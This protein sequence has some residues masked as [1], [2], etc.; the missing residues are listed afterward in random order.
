MIHPLETY[1]RDLRDIRATGAAVPETSFYAPLA[2]LL[3]AIGHELKP[4]VRCVMNLANRGAGIPDGGLFTEDQ[5]Q[6]GQEPL[7]GALP[8]RGAIEVKPTGNDALATAGGAQV[9]RYWNAYG[10]VLVTN[11]R[12]FVLVGRTR[13]GQPEILERYRLAENEK[14]FWQAVQ[15]PRTLSQAHGE[16]F[17][18]FLKRVMLYAAELTE[19]KDVAWF[20]ASYAREA[21]RRLEGS[22]L[23]ALATIRQAFEQALGLKFQGEQG[24]HFFR[25]SFVQTLFYGVF[26]AWV[27]WARQHQGDATAR[28]H[29]HET[30]YFLRVPMIQVLYEQVASPSKLKPLGLDEV[31][32]WATTAL[33]RV[34]RPAFFEKFNQEHAVQYFYE[35]FLE[36]FDPEL[37]E[38]LG[39]WYTP[40]EIVQYM[41]ERVDR[42][43]REELGIESGLADPRVYVLDPCC[44]TGAYLVHVLERIARTLREQGGDA[45]VANDLKKAAASRIFG[46]EIMPAPFVIAHLQLGLVLQNLGAPLSEAT[47]ERAAV[48]LTNSLT[49]WEPPSGAKAVIVNKFTGKPVHSVAAE[50]IPF[51]EFVQEMEMANAIKQDK[52]ILV[53]LGN[54]P[55]NGYAGVALEEERELSNA[56]RTTQRAPKPQGQGLN[57]LYVRFFRM[58]ER[59]IVDGSRLGIVCFISNYSWLDGLSFTGMRERYLEAFDKIWIDCLNGDK[60]KTG[61][62]TPWGAPDPSAFSTE[63]SR[64]G[65]QVG[66]AIGLMVRQEQHA[67]PAKVH[68]RHLWGKTKRDQ[69]LESLQK[70]IAGQYELLNPPVEIGLPLMP[71]ATTEDYM[72][73]L[74]LPALFPISIPGVK[75]SRDMFLIDVDKDKLLKRLSSYF[76]A[77][78]SHEAM[79]QIDPGVMSETKQF[80]ARKTR[81]CLQERGFLEEYVIKYAYR[82]FDN[83]WVYWEPSGDL[84]D[85]KREEL[86]Q[87][88]IPSNLFLTS[89]KK[90]E[91]QDEGTPFYTSN[92]LPDWHL[93]RPGSAIFPL[94]VQDKLLST[95]DFFGSTQSNAEEFVHN[96]SDQ[97]IEY[98]Q[99]LLGISMSRSN[100]S[101]SMIWFHA[102]AIGSSPAYL[103]ENASALWQDWPRIPLPDK[104]D[105]LE[106]SADLGRRVAALLDP[107][108]EVKGISGGKPRPELRLMGIV[109]AVDCGQLDPASG[110]LAITAGWGNYGRDGITMPGRGLTVTRDYT[111]GELAAIEQGADALDLTLAEALALLGETTCDVYLNTRACWRNVPR[112]VWT[113]TIGG[114]QVI[115]KWLSY[116]EEKVLGRTLRSEEAREVTA[117]VRRL[118]ALRLLQPAL[119]ANYRA[120]KNAPHGLD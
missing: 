75:T 99:Q 38:Q 39:V 79:K 37:R 110:D 20:L 117:M 22:E 40:H 60:Y 48:Y 90:A 3:N 4:R 5:L 70:D 107:D 77:S 73:W 19:P 25:S 1:L 12:D 120:V 57:D 81:E 64:E 8:A 69:L 106:H 89:R 56:Y 58:A 29:W 91:R 52:P 42:V 32:E 102:L 115:K 18:E 16:R 44:G 108:V 53:I 14:E 100:K 13:E 63:M 23:A 27:I 7:A 15:H 11:Y 67:A 21:A 82:P 76:D 35:P 94:L 87:S 111:A 9:T 46:F 62:V 34:S 36:A 104:R 61:K 84:L 71:S 116:R 88:I 72:N 55:Y 50:D 119:D 78:I 83:V 41:V 33:G 109:A 66:T 54:P 118:A 114:Y 98:L 59:K 103:E 113:Y 86:F 80:A 92:H 10:Q 85:R 45:L 97:A 96:L 65:I 51:D 101:S 43:L 28:F 24:D 68:F 6:R 17:N 95:P 112:N 47:G 49:G 93:T 30:P 74:L 105:K 26:S 31:L 2:H